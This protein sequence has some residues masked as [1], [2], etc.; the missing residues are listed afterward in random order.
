MIVFRYKRRF[1][2]DVVWSES[3][4]SNDAAS[5]AGSAWTAWE[6]EHWRGAGSVHA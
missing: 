1:L 5:V 2:Q 3:E 4:F 6:M